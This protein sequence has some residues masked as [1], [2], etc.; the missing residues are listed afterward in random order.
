MSKVRTSDGYPLEIVVV[1]AEPNHG[2][3]GITFC[4][5]KF[6]LNA[7][8]GSWNRNLD[9]DLDAIR[10]WGASLVVTLVE[11]SELELLRV[12]QLGD[13]VRARD[14][15]W[16]HLPIRDLDVP[17]AS[18]ET[19]W[20]THGPYIRRSLRGGHD[21]LIHCRGGL[22]RSGMIAA[23]LLAELGMP[24]GEAILAVRSVR[25]GAI[26]TTAQEDLVKRT[27]VIL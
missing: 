19:N 15:H 11:Q 17:S 27:K 13:A 7:K 26:E 12:G 4:P 20:T 8:I 22:G 2:R 5:G 24:P 21:V 10:I 3:I 14:M 1:R 9:A 6:D 18:F 23:R 16:L 25:K